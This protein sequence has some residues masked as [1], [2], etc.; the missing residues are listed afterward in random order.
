MKSK[1]V[2]LFMGGL[3]ILLS[4][5]HTSTVVSNRLI[6]KRKYTSGWFLNKQ[7]RKGSG[8]DQANALTEKK[9]QKKGYDVSTLI[10]T[11]IQKVESEEQPTYISETELAEELHV[12]VTDNPVME[13]KAERVEEAPS[14]E[15]IEDEKVEEATVDK[16]P[17]NKP[18]VISFV[19][20]IAAIMFLV[21][22]GIELVASEFYVVFLLGLIF[23]VASLVISILALTKYG[24]KR[25]YRA[26]A[27][28]PAYTVAIFLFVSLISII[29]WIAGGGGMTYKLG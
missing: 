7:G 16:G 26:L 13:Y 19:L 6:Q 1:V 17:V 8:Q 28:V 27:W 18:A 21:V 25:R 2:L 4:A 10:P 15:V 3:L 11:E 24:N 5:C 14:K 9:E 12:S 29:I 20:F 23:L 22:G